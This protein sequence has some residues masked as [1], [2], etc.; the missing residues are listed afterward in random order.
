MPHRVV[1]TDTFV[2][3]YESII[4]YLVDVLAAPQAAGKLLEAMDRMRDTLAEMPTIRAVSRK[5]SLEELGL[6]EYLV[7]NYVVLYRV[8]SNVVYLEHIFHTSQDYEAC[9]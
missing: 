5:P 7:R 2:A 1:S 6:R 9:V 4:L 3:Q 8:E